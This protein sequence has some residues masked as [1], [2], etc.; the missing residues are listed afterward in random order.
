MLSN[1]VG[2]N[3]FTLRP[4][5]AV[6]NPARSGYGTETPHGADETWR[7]HVIPSTEAKETQLNQRGL[8][9]LVQRAERVEAPQ[10][11]S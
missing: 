2:S 11:V 1:R 10:L 8:S 4:L 9:S 7:T 5:R 3:A 6:S